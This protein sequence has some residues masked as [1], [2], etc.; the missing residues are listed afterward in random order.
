MVKPE[1]TLGLLSS[2]P[3]SHLDSGPQSSTK[4]LIEVCL[5]KD[6]RLSVFSEAASAPFIPEAINPIVTATQKLCGMIH[7]FGA[8]LLVWKDLPWRSLLETS[9]YNGWNF[10]N[11]FCISLVSWGKREEESR[12]TLE[13]SWAVSHSPFFSATYC[14]R[15]YLWAV[16][17]CALEELNIQLR[18][19]KMW[20]VTWT[21]GRLE[22]R[23]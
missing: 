9:I 13:G 19:N 2:Q 5:R 4:E 10:N 18:E 17:F 7:G 14:L 22:Y 23:G 20:L 1:C 8:E 15:F 6:L 12:D 21:W 11:F 16:E 3:V